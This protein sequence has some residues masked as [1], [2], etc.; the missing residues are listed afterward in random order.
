MEHMDLSAI[1]DS[2]TCPI[3]G[4]VMTDPVQGNDGHTYERS[5]IIEWLSRNPISPQTRQPMTESDLKVNASIRFL[6]DKYHYE[7]PK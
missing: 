2:I 3:T 4:D 5:A 7:M 6:C 1:R